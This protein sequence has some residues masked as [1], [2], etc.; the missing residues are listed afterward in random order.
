VQQKSYLEKALPVEIQ[1]VNNL[2]QDGDPESEEMKMV[3][4]LAQR[5]LDSRDQVCIIRYYHRLRTFG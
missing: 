2:I 3:A 5:A 4:I 1:R